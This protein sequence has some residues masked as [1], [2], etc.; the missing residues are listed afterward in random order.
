MFGPHARAAT[1][2]EAAFE[3]ARLVEPV[4]VSFGPST[5]PAWSVVR[6]DDNLGANRPAVY[7]NVG[8]SFR[9]RP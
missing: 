9:G 8:D 5:S 3:A 6:M 4:I 2:F 7:R 1:I